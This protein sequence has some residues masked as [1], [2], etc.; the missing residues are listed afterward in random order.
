MCVHISLVSF[1]SA[2]RSTA[3]ESFSRGIFGLFVSIFSFSQILNAQMIP[4]KEQVI[5][6]LL[7]QVAISSNWQEKDMTSNKPIF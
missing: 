4:S 2:S 7:S 1:D 3:F 5:G 6:I